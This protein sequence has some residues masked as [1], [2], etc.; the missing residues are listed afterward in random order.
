MKPADLDDDHIETT[1]F[2]RFASASDADD[3]TES[4]AQTPFSEKNDN[5]AGHGK[6]LE[7]TV[8][9]CRK[10]SDGLVDCD[11]CLNLALEGW[12]AQSNAKER[13]V[14]Q[15]LLNILNAAGPTGLDMN[16]LVVSIH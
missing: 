14:C 2:A 9:C 12:F 13:E 5:N 6:T 11:S 3:V 16:T 15:H 7:G 10:Y 4:R 8:A 1:I